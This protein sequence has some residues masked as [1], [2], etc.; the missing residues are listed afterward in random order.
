MDKVAAIKTARVEKIKTTVS[1]L[2]SN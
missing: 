1:V 2:V